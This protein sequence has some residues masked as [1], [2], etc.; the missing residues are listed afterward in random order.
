[1]LWNLARRGAWYGVGKFSGAWCWGLTHRYCRQC[2]KL[3]GLT[4]S[5]MCVSC[6]YK[7]F[8]RAMEEAEDLGA[9]SK[10]GDQVETDKPASSGEA[11]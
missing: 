5:P 3:K 8:V 7:N 2:R 10:N 9:E 4:F 6:Q 1:M 11:R